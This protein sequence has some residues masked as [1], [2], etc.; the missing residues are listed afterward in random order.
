MGICENKG[1]GFA[2]RSLDPRRDTPDTADTPETLDTLDS[3]NA[4]DTQDTSDSEATLET[5][6]CPQRFLILAKHC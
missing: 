5:L 6:H 1:G 2:L 3:A 4:F